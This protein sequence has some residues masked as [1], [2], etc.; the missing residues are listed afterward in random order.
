MP[1]QCSTMNYIHSPF[2]LNLLRHDL[3]NSLALNLVIFLPQP[4]KYLGLQTCATRLPFSCVGGREVENYYFGILRQDLM[5]PRM[6]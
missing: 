5:H 4:P 3:I 2:L 1:G 6:A